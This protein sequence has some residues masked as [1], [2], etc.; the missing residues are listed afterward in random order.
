MPIR[1]LPTP[2]Y[3]GRRGGRCQTDVSSSLDLDL[4]D[5]EPPGVLS[6]RV[7]QPHRRLAMGTMHDRRCRRT[8]GHRP[9]TER[10]A[11]AGRTRGRHDPLRFLLREELPTPEVSPAMRCL[12]GGEPLLVLPGTTSS[13]PG[14]AIDTSTE[15][16]RMP[17]RAL[18]LH[19]QPSTV[20][21]QSCRERGPSFAERRVACARSPGRRPRASEPCPS[22]MT[23]GHPGEE[24]LWTC[25]RNSTIAFSICDSPGCS[26]G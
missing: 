7:L 4:C 16:P 5:R 24:W 2:R 12:C 21:R 13:R 14:R 19:R 22:P 6:R 15:V 9:H 18:R 3:N 20:A 25:S 17:A 1:A 10:L 23:G 11:G 26:S 8:P